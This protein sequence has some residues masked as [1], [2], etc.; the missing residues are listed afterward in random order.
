MIGCKDWMTKSCFWYLIFHLCILCRR[1]LYGLWPS[2]VIGNC[3]WHCS[4]WTNVFGR[5]GP[6]TYQWSW[7]SAWRRREATGRNLQEAEHRPYPY[8]KCP[9]FFSFALKCL[10][11]WF[12]NGFNH[13]NHGSTVCGDMVSS[14]WQAFIA[15]CNEQLEEICRGDTQ[16]MVMKQLDGHPESRSSQIWGS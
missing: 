2:E 1:W 9:Y 11:G 12:W 14:H 5:W 10:L 3:L 15:V 13:F 8:N 6:L 7:K 16:D 4:L